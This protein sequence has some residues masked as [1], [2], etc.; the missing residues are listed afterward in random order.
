VGR[1]PVRGVTISWVYR[2]DFDRFGFYDG[3]GAPLVL[4]TH[5]P[6]LD[7]PAKRGTLRTLLR[8]W[9]AT[10]RSSERYVLESRSEPLVDS[11]SPG[12]CPSSPSSGRGW[13]HAHSRYLD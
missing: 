12:S 3:H 10:A 9:A 1:D 2:A 8:F 6:S 5:D 7:T 11:C 4:M 13:R